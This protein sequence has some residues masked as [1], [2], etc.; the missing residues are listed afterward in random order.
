MVILCVFANV[1]SSVFELHE[2]VVH[3]L[4]DSSAMLPDLIVLWV[5]FSLITDEVILLH[6]IL[7][8]CLDQDPLIMPG[9]VICAIQLTYTACDRVC[10]LRD[11]VFLR[12]C[13]EVGHG[14]LK[15]VTRLDVDNLHRRTF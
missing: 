10:A 4:N 1:I 14:R 7:L 3:E 2:R 13:A 15:L 5:V 8:Q 12:D 9:C 6:E 11:L